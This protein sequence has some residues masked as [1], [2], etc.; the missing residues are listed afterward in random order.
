[1]EELVGPELVARYAI[2]DHDGTNDDAH[3]AVGEV[4]GTPVRLQR[5]YVE[6][7]LRIVTGFVEPH[8]FA[9]FSGGPKAVCP[10]LA[11]NRRF[12]R[13]TTRVALPMPAPRS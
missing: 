2:V 5:E 13:H 6:A 10:G 3:V 4:D 11:A 9:G 7:D 12:W 1:M 8:F